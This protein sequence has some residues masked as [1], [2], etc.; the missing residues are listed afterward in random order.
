MGLQNVHGFVVWVLLSYEMIHVTPV[1]DRQ[2]DYRTER[3]PAQSGNP[4]LEIYHPVSP[5]TNVENFKSQVVKVKL[6]VT[7][8]M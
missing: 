7:M 4:C 1:T 8:T 5:S 6:G 2:T 3:E